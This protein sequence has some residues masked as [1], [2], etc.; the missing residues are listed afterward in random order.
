MIERIRDVDDRVTAFFRSFYEDKRS[1]FAFD[2]Y[3]RL[4]A[5]AQQTFDARRL[6]EIGGG[7]RPLFEE[8]EVRDASF[9][10][11]VCDISRTELAHLSDIYPT[12]HFDI[13][14]PL[15]A[16]FASQYDLMFSKMVIEHVRDVRQAYRNISALLAPGG[17]C[18]NFHPVL[19]SL[20][21]VINRLFPES[22]TTKML[23]AFYPL[24]PGVHVPKFPAFYDLCV[25]DERTARAVEGLG[26]TAV[27]VMP[28]YGHDYFRKIPGLRTV[29]RITSDLCRKYDLSHGASY[30]YTIA[31]KG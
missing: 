7:R 25:A 8:D 27:Y 20:P 17:I 22:I 28:F 19:Y 30:A 2:Q 10:Y 11:T 23:D 15:E 21:F 29:D 24:P 16:G 18:I 4:V 14:Q 5:S 31:V 3:K 26:F 1:D 13:G 9:S 6:L 12:L